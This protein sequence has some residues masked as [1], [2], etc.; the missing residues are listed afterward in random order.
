[1]DGP[2]CYITLNNRDFRGLD[3]SGIEEGG[4]VVQCLCCYVQPLDHSSPS[5]TKAKISRP[6]RVAVDAT[7][8]ARSAL[9]SKEG[10]TRQALPSSSAKAQ[11]GGAIK[12]NLWKCVR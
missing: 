8:A 12:A 2:L 5:S 6:R 7:P 11:S 4:A 1:V 9:H 3:N 10:L